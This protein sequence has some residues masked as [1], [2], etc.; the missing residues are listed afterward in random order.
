M[1]DPA[2]RMIR[3]DGAALASYAPKHR[4]TR[5]VVLFDVGSVQQESPT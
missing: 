5:P 1:T 4:D 3:F 2:A